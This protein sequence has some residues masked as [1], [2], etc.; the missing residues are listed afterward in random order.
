MA[1]V[2]SLVKD[3]KYDRASP[4]ANVGASHFVES[5]AWAYMIPEFCRH[6]NES[7]KCAGRIENLAA[8]EELSQLAQV[9]M[10]SRLMLAVGVSELSSFNEL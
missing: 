8:L 1:G 6:R 9:L 5:L 2:V 7:N 3:L 4:E 10:E